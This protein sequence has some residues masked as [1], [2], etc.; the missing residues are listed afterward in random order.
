MGDGLADL[1]GRQVGRHKWQKGGN[2]SIEGTAAFATSSFLVSMAMIAWFHGFG[3]MAVSPSAAA[4][5]VAAVSAFCAAVELLPPR[6]V[7]DDN[8]SVPVAAIAM[9][10]LLFR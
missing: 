6:L 3:V 2:K 5:R 7:G 9:G 8:F 4:G 1:V 10:R